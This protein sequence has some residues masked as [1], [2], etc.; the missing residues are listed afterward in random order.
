MISF[1]S[2]IV[3]RRKQSIPENKFAGRKN[4]RPANSREKQL[5]GNWLSKII[6][7]VYLHPVDNDFKMQVGTVR[8]ACGAHTSNLL[9]AGHRLPDAD[10]NCALK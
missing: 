8:L 5:R 9:S 2:S 7:G 6:G 10:Q 4:F 3:G 1:S